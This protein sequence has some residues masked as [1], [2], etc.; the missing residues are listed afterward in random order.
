M[1]EVLLEGIARPRKK[2][3]GAFQ[4]LEA[5]VN[6]RAQSRKLRQVRCCSSGDYSASHYETVTKCAK[7]LTCNRAHR[8]DARP[9]AMHLFFLHLRN[10]VSVHVRGQ[11]FSHIVDER[12]CARI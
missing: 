12:F 4:K 7:L 10:G 2:Q 9:V 5:S 11:F 6:L 8:Y 3:A 1:K